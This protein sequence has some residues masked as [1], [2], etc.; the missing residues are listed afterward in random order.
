MDSGFGAEDEYNTYTKPLFD[1]EGVSSSSIYRPTREET[2]H[3]ADEQYDTLLQVETNKSFAGAGSG[4]V[5]RS[6]PVQ[7]EKDAT[8]ID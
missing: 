1:R 4:G 5:S 7:F 2:E 8:K 6:T 3:T